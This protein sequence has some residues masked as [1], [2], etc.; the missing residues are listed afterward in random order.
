MLL[1]AS[2]A[3]ALAA[4]GEDGPDMSPFSS[5]QAC[6]D[7]HVDDKMLMPFEAIVEC[8]IDHPIG[9]MQ[10]ACGADR[11]ECINYITANLDQTDAS[12]VEVM[13][14]CESYDNMTP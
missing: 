12:T 8:C 9:G 4:C 7:K 5:F 14:A 1:A 13:G 10:D 2:A 6:F 3:L 11:A